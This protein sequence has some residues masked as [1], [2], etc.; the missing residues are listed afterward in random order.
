MTTFKS[1]QDCVDYHFHDSTL[2]KEAFLA[3]GA[4]ISNKDIEGPV[5][6]NKRLALVGDA[7]LR[8]AVLDEWF[9]SGTSTAEGHGRV[10]EVG[11]NERLAKVAENWN[12]K[13]YMIENPCQ[14]GEAPRE[15]L[16]STVEAILGAVWLDSYQDFGEVQ[17]VFKKLCS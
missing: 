16:A 15:L 13:K 7:V 5:K 3:S 9:E 6:G 10:V 17:K 2:L 12:L 4:P 1:I 8:L 11:T 14:Q